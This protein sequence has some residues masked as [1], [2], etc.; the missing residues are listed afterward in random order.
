MLQ[1]SVPQRC[2]Q[3]ST[4]QL[5]P[6]QTAPLR[7]QPLYSPSVSCQA[8]RPASEHNP[9]TSG[10]STP[11]RRRRTTTRRTTKALEPLVEASEQPVTSS[12]GRSTTAGR[13][14]PAAGALQQ[15]DSPA[16]PFQE[17]QAASKQSKQPSVH[18]EHSLKSTAT[19]TEA[20]V[21]QTKAAAPKPRRRRAS[22]P[23][24]PDQQVEPPQICY[25]LSSAVGSYSDF[26]RCSVH[27]DEHEH[28]RNGDSSAS[29]GSRRA[30][31]SKA[32]SSRASSQPTS[33]PHSRV[34]NGAGT[35]ASDRSADDVRGLVYGAT[36]RFSD[37]AALRLRRRAMVVW[38]EVRGTDVHMARV[39]GAMRS[40]EPFLSHRVSSHSA[41]LTSGRM[42]TRQ[43]MHPATN[44]SVG[45][46]CCCRMVRARC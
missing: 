8:R 10:D 45:C 27:L 1:Q 40:A 19:Q 2:P 12:S 14:Q 39:A 33:R 46:C 3:L 42:W 15:H 44:M 25:T 9:S 30:S 34:G 17:K 35:H 31:S 4:S 18:A 20:G 36:V 32:S 23:V 13:R 7:L 16:D 37:S 21:V 11:G 6:R 38:E 26:N 43:S 41:R 5:T 24:Q 22:S 29:N 28:S